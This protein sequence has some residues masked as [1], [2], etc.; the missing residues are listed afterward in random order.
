MKKPLLH[1]CFAAFLL[2]ASFGCST[3]TAKRL[4]QLE[5][6]M[7]ETKVKKILGDD[8]IAKASMTDSTGVPLQLW[9]Y[10]DK[11]SKTE[12]HVYFKDSK[13]AQWGTQDKLDFPALNL[14][15]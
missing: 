13:L 2:R 1:C 5:V 4:N 9:V 11:N 6:G 8:Y 14:P 3:S 12:Y 15:K 10:T 7:P